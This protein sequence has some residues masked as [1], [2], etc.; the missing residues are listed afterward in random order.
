MKIIIVSI[1]IGLFFFITKAING[2]EDCLFGFCFGIRCLLRVYFAHW[3]CSYFLH[4]KR[5]QELSDDIDKIFLDENFLVH[6]KNELRKR[7]ENINE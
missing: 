7:Q 3:L 1:L 2:T 4:R 5:I 6:F